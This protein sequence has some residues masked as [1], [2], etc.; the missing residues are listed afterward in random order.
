MRH[1]LFLAVAGLLVQT[2]AAQKIH[3]KELQSPVFRIDKIYKSM[4][5]PSAVQAFQLEETTNRELLWIVGYEAIV[6]EP[7][8]GEKISQEF[9]CHSNLDYLP[10]SYEKTIGPHSLDGRFFTLSQGQQSVTFPSGFGIPVYSDEEIRL[11]TQV[12]NLNDPNLDKRVRYR[13]NVN[14]IKDSETL[15]PMRPLRQLGIFGMKALGE[16]TSCEV[17]SS[18]GTSCAVGKA[19]MEGSEMVDMGG[20]KLTGHWVVEPGREV[21][22]TD[23]T[24]LLALSEE[25]SVHY[26]AVHLHPFAESLELKDDT[27]G[28]IL[29]KANVTAA[30]KRVGIKHIDHFSSIEGFQLKPEHDYSLTSIYNNT[31]NQNVDSMAVMYLYGAVENAPLNNQK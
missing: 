10:D 31:T 1:L 27:T 20:G 18:H 13:V 30:E 5:G 7:E 15:S 25:F 16:T 3:N 8:T 6:I 21:N 26:I 29:F 14:Y 22:S 28:E 12:L 24:P 11:G 19:A 4:Q 23:V 9:L 2:S 17:A